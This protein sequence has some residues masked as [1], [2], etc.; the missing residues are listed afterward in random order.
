MKPLAQ[1]IP[2]A[3]SCLAFAATVP[4][5]PSEGRQEP[6]PG[7]LEGVGVIQMPG[8]KLPLDL[9][10]VD[11][12]GR[13]VR[14]GDYFGKGRPVLLNLGY[15][16]CPMLCNLVLNGVVE[17]LKPLSF[18]PGAEFEIV[19]VSIDPNETPQLAAAKKQSYLESYERAGVGGGWHFLTG[20]EAPIKALADSVGFK[21]KYDAGSNQYAHSAAM[22]VVTPDGKLSRVLSGIQYNARTLRLALAEA[23]EGKIGSPIDQVLLF[24]FHFDSVT[25]RYALAATQLMKAGGALTVV[26]VAA[27]LSLFWV[28]EH[29]RRK[30]ERPEAN[31]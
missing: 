27:F 8:A 13:T 30:A 25:G 10:F 11:D 29:R 26:A 28:R 22:F 2:L 1:L 16:R 6:L 19:V 4:A 31:A 24:C 15:Y 17:G 9:P 18:N 20:A 14:L 5:I 21:Y 12:E 23:S 3:M 7:E